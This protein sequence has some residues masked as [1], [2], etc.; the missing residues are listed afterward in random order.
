MERWQPE[1]EQVLEYARRMA[2]L[3]LVVGTSGN[4]SLRLPPEA[5]RP[6]LAITPSGRRYES[7]TAADIVVVAFDG[8]VIDGSLTP[9]V[10][11]PLHIAVYR[12]RP[13]VGAVVHTHSVHA[14]AMAV[15]G[16]AIPPVLEDQ[17][18]GLGGPIEL[19]PR[20]PSGTPEQVNG[21][22]D[23]LG[24]RSAVLLANHGVVATGRTLED[25]LTAAELTE[26]TARIYLLA[27]ATGPVNPLPDEAVAALRKHYLRHRD[28]AP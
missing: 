1:R 6:L 13:D 12:A 14:S 16:Q 11:T 5:G 4:V 28:G 10:E 23:A 9:S 27:R 18:A 8:E 19:A 21:A 22:L 15:A 17:V 20:A 26:K 7:L 24:D 25:A 3:S 2:A